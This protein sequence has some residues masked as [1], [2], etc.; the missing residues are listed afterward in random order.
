MG[1]AGTDGLDLS[2]D[3]RGA[4]RAPDGRR[5]AEPRVRPGRGGYLYVI[6][7]RVALDGDGLSTGDAAKITGP[8]ELALS[9]DAAAE[10]ILIDVPHEY[11]PV[12]VWAGEW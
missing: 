11:K 5:I 8:L 10:L 12:G 9:T 7:G 1:P 4:R 6:D 2:Q 3:A